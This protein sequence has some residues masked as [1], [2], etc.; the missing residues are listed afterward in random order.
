MNFLTRKNSGGRQAKRRKEEKNLS[1]GN[2]KACHNIDQHCPPATTY[3][4][5]QSEAPLPRNGGGGLSVILLL[6]TSAMGGCL[7]GAAGHN[8]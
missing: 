1:P 8:A 7:V 6:R 4:F 5:Y 3:S 2:R